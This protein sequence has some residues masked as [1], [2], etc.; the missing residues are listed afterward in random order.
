MKLQF[1]GKASPKF[2]ATWMNLCKLLALR[3]LL[4]H[5]KGGKKGKLSKRVKAFIFMLSADSSLGKLACSLTPV[6][7]RLGM[8]LWS[9][10]YIYSFNAHV[11]NLR[12]MGG[13]A[14]LPILCGLQKL[15]MNMIVSDKV[16]AKLK[17]PLL[18]LFNK[19]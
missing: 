19:Y 12:P 2:C 4:W 7:V 14:C 13:L 6:G 16:Y 8:K 11:S 15:Q 3:L 5:A 17:R 1:Q 18:C 9:D 10:F